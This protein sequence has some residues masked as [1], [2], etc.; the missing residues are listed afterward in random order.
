MGR[1]NGND[2]VVVGGGVVGLAIAY[3]LAGRGRDV[4]LLER[5]HDVGGGAS[6]GNAGYIVPSHATPLASF[7][8]IRDGARWMFQRDAPLHIN[9][10][11][12]LLPWLTRFVA[13]STPARVDRGT[14]LLRALANESLGL[15]RILADE[16]GTSFRGS[17]ILNLYET[18]AGFEAGCAEARAHVRGGLRVEVRNGEETAE[19]EP[20]V[21][22]NVAG[23]V[24]YPDEGFCDPQRFC[25]ALAS[26]A[27]ARGVEI[28]RGVEALS[29]EIDRP[30][31]VAVKTSRGSV[32]ASAVIVSAGVWTAHLLRTVGVGLPIEAGT[33]YHVEVATDAAQ[34]RLPVFLKEA[35]VTTTPLASGLRLTG[36][37]DLG[38]GGRMT[39]SER[40]RPLIEAAR[41]V[42]LPEAVARVTRTW[43]GPRPCT[44]DGLP[45]IGAVGPFENLFVSSGHA[46]LGVTLAPVAAKIVGDLFEGSHV[47]VAAAL[48][49]RRFR[50]AKMPFAH[51]R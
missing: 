33:G 13:A 41:R 42:F 39:E 15:H 1:P 23:S 40:T 10:R 2:V 29:L 4:T 22:S 49:P 43:H 27:S 34:P 7:A 26:A 46:M 37:L 36:G 44:P 18:T 32:T 24:L 17:G 30:H 11:P 14:R 21:V 6:A 3:E 47:P 45:A 51:R 9:L 48:D 19:L 35:H 50:A 12:R 28:Q 8:S 25:N 5:D 38:V 20:A 31:L 16:I